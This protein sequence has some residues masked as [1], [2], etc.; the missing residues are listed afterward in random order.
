[1]RIGMLEDDLSQIELISLWAEASGDDLE[2][3]TTGKDFREAVV[4]NEYD[5]LII[6]WQLPDTS[7]IK[8]LDWLRLEKNR[9]YPS[10]S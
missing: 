7:G 1:M 6:D 2:S 5:L 9:H 3:Y 8:E 10:S 4:K